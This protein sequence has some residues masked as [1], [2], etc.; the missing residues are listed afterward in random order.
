MG[1]EH[2]G[3]GERLLGR[4][5]TWEMQ[6]GEAER[7]NRVEERKVSREERRQSCRA[8][9]EKRGERERKCESKEKRER[10][11]RGDR[12]GLKGLKVVC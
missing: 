11:K 4:Q 6:L 5:A 1:I 10:V 3:G 9:R 2:G 12:E 8:H 7:E